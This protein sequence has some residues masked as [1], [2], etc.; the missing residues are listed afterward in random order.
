LEARAKYAANGKEPAPGVDLY[1]NA[2]VSKI[3]GIEVAKPKNPEVRW[4]F[5][6]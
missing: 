5:F 6:D 1:F 4:T 3:E 2:Y